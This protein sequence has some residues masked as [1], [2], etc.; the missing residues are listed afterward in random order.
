MASVETSSDAPDAGQVAMGFNYKIL[1]SNKFVSRSVKN[2]PAVIRQRSP[3]TVR[4]HLYRPV[5]LFAVYVDF[6]DVTST[7]TCPAQS[8]R[9]ERTHVGGFPFGVA[10]SLMDPVVANLTNLEDASRHLSLPPSLST[11]LNKAR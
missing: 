2:Y 6:M 10:E 5:D 4:R 8:L 9:H 7:G 1:E 11:L 3:Q